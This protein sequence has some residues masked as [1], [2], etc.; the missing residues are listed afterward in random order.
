MVRREG[1]ENSQEG[2]YFMV[3]Q[4]SRFVI[5]PYSPVRFP[6]EPLISCDEDYEYDASS[7]P[8]GTTNLISPG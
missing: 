1:D 8:A 5:G 2:T 3:Y 6:L 7:I 4:S